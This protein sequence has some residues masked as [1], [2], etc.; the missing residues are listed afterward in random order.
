MINEKKISICSRTFYNNLDLRRKLEKLFK[1]IKFNK[2]KK[3]LEGKSLVN[4]LKG[5]EIA[6]VGLE[7]M[8]QKTLGQLPDLKVIVKYGV[9]L[10]KIDLKYLKKNKIGFFH[11][12]GF[13]KRSVSELALSY[14]LS[15]SRKLIDLNS[16][17]KK[18]TWGQL[19]GNNLSEKKIGI[20]GCG[21]IGKD[22]INLLKPF[23]CKIYVNDIV[24]IDNCLVEN[25]IML[26]KKIDIFSECD[27][28]SI[29]IPF[30]KKNKNLINKKY[31]QLMKS[32]AS[33]INTSRGGIVDEDDLYKV[34]KNKSI[35]S[36]YFDVL[37]TEPPKKNSKIL[38]LKNFFISPHIG[39]STK[40]SILKGGL[41]CIKKLVQIK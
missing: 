9:G 31:L 12:P 4:F 14:M 37:N 40:E 41:L 3:S 20:I 1:N 16:L 26:K 2:S 27:F 17:V 13:N 30:N 21:F 11:F 5:S 35:G 23:K 7:K 24:N 29:H 22:L 36:A 39:G 38:K 33:L 32:T 8:N 25:K 19:T 15:I 28:I 34:L 6:L 10:D 18:N